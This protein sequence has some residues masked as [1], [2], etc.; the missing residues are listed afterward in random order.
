MHS[1]CVFFHLSICFRLD[2]KRI[3]RLASASVDKY[4]V[5]TNFQTQF[6]DEINL[7]REHRRRHRTVHTAICLCDLQILFIIRFLQRQNA[8]NPT[9]CCYCYR[10][11][12][13][14]VIKLIYESFWSNVANAMVLYSIHLL[15]ILT[16]KLNWSWTENFIILEFYV[17]VIVFLSAGS[18]FQR[19]VFLRNN[20]V[21][22]CALPTVRRCNECLLLSWGAEDQLIETT[23]SALFWQKQ[24]HLHRI[25]NWPHFYANRN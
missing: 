20:V 18:H 14:S 7:E 11:F 5:V 8:I 23:R 21:F 16:D 3:T 25:R 9:G 12:A 1:L 6:E 24:I 2:N 13:S 19:R 10:T 22:M 15:N 4:T 17:L